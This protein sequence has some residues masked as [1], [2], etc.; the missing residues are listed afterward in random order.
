M[1]G[2]NFQRMAEL[3]GA[4]GV[5]KKA[6]FGQLGMSE[7]TF[8]SW[9]NGTSIPKENSVRKIADRLGVSLSDLR[10]NSEPT[11]QA[12]PPIVELPQDASHTDNMSVQSM[13]TQS[14]SVDF[15]E[16]ELDKY[17]G[18]SACIIFDTCSIMNTPDLL[19]FVNGDEL[20]VVP[21]VVLNELENNKLKFGHND[22]GRKAQH[23]ISAIHNYKHHRPVL[24]ADDNI[25]LIPSVYRAENSKNET[26]DNKILSV[27]IR[28]KLYIPTPVLFITDDYSLSLKATGQEINVCTSEEF[29]SGTIPLFPPV[30]WA[31]KEDSEE[32]GHE[33]DPFLRFKQAEGNEDYNQMVL[34]SIILKRVSSVRKHFND[35]IDSQIKELAELYMSLRTRKV[36]PIK[37]HLMYA[38]LKAFAAKYLDEEDMEALALSFGSAYQDVLSALSGSITQI[39]G[40][41][42]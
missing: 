22:A 38:D 21:K 20:V 2:Y 29:K 24:F 12:T 31:A 37:K 33:Y 35:P 5:S 32:K 10:T 4:T 3:I 11:L 28:H 23:A 7:K 14:E 17:R 1:L 18:C 13:H 36:I 34:Y 26:N 9:M 25:S 27:V 16:D 42:E 30:D 40:D 8:S 39:V 6:F 41:L 19:E 15:S